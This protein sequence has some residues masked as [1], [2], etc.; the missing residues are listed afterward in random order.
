MTVGYLASSFDLLNVRDLDLL[1]QA[2][3]QCTVLIV[4]VFS[5]GVAHARTGRRPVVPVAE[6]KALVS[7]V[8]GVSEVLVHDE[9]WQPLAVDTIFAVAGEPALIG[10]GNTWL[11]SPRRQTS[12]PVLRAA[13]MRAPG[14]EVA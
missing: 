14:E 10:I 8:R 13:L 9:Y 12:S 5:D 7:H 11:L 3:Q 1:A 2:R 4:G 6:R